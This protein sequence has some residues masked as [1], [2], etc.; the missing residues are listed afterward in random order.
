ML[1]RMSATPYAAN[2]M[3]SVLRAVLEWSV[4]RGYRA[5]NPAVGIKRL[6]VG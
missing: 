5:D 1:D 3:L 6:K 4:P 2:Q